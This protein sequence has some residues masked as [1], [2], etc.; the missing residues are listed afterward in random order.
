MLT[1]HL[2]ARFRNKTFILSMLGAI[3][4]LIQQLGFKNIIPSNY[5]DII[6]SVLSILVMLG[7]VVDTSTKGIS[8]QVISDATVQAVNSVEEVKTESGATSVNNT[9]EKESETNASVDNSSNVQVGTDNSVTNASTDNST[10]VI[11]LVE[12][13]AE[14]EK[15][16]ATLASIQSTASGATVQA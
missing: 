3:V 14:N 7:I 2:K 5:A 6:N 8:D 13:Q 4:L 15:L 1:L 16:K 11:D 12:I 10:P 9:V